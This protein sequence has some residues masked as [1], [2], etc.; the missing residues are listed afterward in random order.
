M[1]RQEGSG[2]IRFWAPPSSA[3]GVTAGLPSNANGRGLLAPGYCPLATRQ[4]RRSRAAFT[5]TELLVTIAII[6]LLSG[7]MFGALQLA[8]E[9]AREQATKATIAKLHT[10]IMRRYESYMTRRA[11]IRI[12][13]TAT[14]DQAARMRLDAI[15]DLMRME[16]PDCVADVATGPINFAT[17]LGPV[18]HVEEP[19]LHRLYASRPPSAVND[20]AQCL[21]LIVS[22]GSPEAMEQFS[23]SEIGM[24]DGN[25]PVFVDGWGRPIAFLR[26]APG[27]IRPASN[28][29]TGNA[30]VD[31]DP[32]DPRRLDYDPSDPTSKGFHLIPLICSAGSGKTIDIFDLDQTSR[33]KRLYTASAIN[34]YMDLSLGRPT[35]G[36]STG[37]I[38]NHHIEAR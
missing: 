4:S 17:W 16:M 35:N 36:T 24:V 21:Y 23:Q 12:P 29:Q 33:S 14:P 37:C 5:L 2:E 30:A 22:L 10:I 8:R 1:E 19:A 3:P 7:M 9:A 26:W 28:I 13:A 32:F 11:P 27:F 34:P 6:G 25:K 18:N 15:R 38:T 31:G 20:S